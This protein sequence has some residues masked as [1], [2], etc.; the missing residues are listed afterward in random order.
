MKTNEK[1][2]IARPLTPKISP[3]DDHDVMP[4]EF[5]DLYQAGY[6]TGLASGRESA[7]RQGYKAGFEDG[8]RQDDAGSAAANAAS[9]IVAE[10]GK[11]RL[12]GLPCTKCRRLIYSDEARCAYCTAPRAARL[13]EPPSATC[14]DPEQA[15]KREPDGGLEFL[16]RSEENC[17][18][19]TPRCDSGR[20]DRGY[21]GSDG[22]GSAG[23][24][25]AVSNQRK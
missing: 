14:C 9:E 16:G 1:T 8:R 13:G 24:T 5:A 21:S 4:G 11:S 7:Y 22:N 17:G 2:D 19:R 10:V 3:S 20:F 12:F 23:P 6:E 15:R 25:V 18:V